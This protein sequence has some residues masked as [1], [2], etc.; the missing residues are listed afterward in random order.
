MNGEMSSQNLGLL[1]CLIIGIELILVGVTGAPDKGNFGETSTSSSSVTLVENSLNR[2]RSA[3]HLNFLTVRKEDFSVSSVHGERDSKTLTQTEILCSSSPCVI[4]RETY[5]YYYHTEELAYDYYYDCGYNESCQTPVYDLAVDC[6]DDFYDVYDFMIGFDAKPCSS[7][8]FS[9]LDIYIDD[10]DVYFDTKD[11]E[12]YRY[13]DDAKLFAVLPAEEASRDWDFYIT[14]YAAVSDY[15][16]FP[17]EEYLP[18][19]DISCYFDCYQIYEEPYCY[20]EDNSETYTCDAY[21]DGDMYSYFIDFEDASGDGNWQIKYVYL[22]L[23]HDSELYETDLIKFPNISQTE[24]A[25]LV[26][27][28]AG[29]SPDALYEQGNLY[30]E[31]YDKDDNLLGTILDE[32]ITTSVTKNID[33]KGFLRDEGIKFVFGNDFGSEYTI[34]NIRIEFI[35]R[36]EY[37]TEYGSCSE[38]KPLYCLQGNLINN[39]VECGCGKGYGCRTDGI[40]VIFP[41]DVDGNCKIDISD[42]AAVGLAYGSQPDDPN[43]NLNADLNGNGQVDIFDLATVGLSY[44]KGC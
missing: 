9:D 4:E 18:N 41:A 10:Q 42:L 3:S 32:L 43:W 6:L 14:D 11:W 26:F 16:T 40:C 2:E 15:L 13:E 7:C 22:Y 25:T 8:S 27:D 36:C 28:V 12:W 1:L 44:G 5:V 24:S 34:E 33:I 20:C 39:C 29:S 21:E 38:I 19:P 35:A 17:P 23:L 31:V 30:V 37:G